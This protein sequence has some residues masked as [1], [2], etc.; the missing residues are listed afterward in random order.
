MA[1]PKQQQPEK[2][3][4]TL[5]NYFSAGSAKTSTAPANDDSSLVDLVSDDSSDEDNNKS[6]RGKRQLTTTKKKA[7]SFDNPP[8]KRFKTAGSVPIKNQSTS[9]SIEPSLQWV[10]LYKPSNSSEVA[11]HAKRRQEVEEA[12]TL[13]RRRAPNAPRLLMLSGPAGCSK[14]AIVNTLYKELGFTRLAEYETPSESTEDLGLMHAFEDFL[15]GIRYRGATD[16]LLVLVED[17]PNISHYE[18]KQAFVKALMQWVNYPQPNLPPLVLIMTEVE[19]ALEN[20]NYFS[21]DSIVVERIFPKPLL[22]HPQVK[23]IKFLPINMTL[24]SK[25]LK[26]VVQKESAK[27]AKLPKKEIDWA[28]RGLAELGDIRSAISGLEF[29]ARWRSRSNKLSPLG[30][31]SQLGLFHAIGRVVHGSHKDKKGQPVQSDEAVVESVLADWDLNNSDSSFNLSIAENYPSAHSSRT[32]IEG[33]DA[34]ADV[35]SLADT[36]IP[37]NLSQLSTDIAARGVRTALRNATETATIPKIHRPLVYSRY[38]KAMRE[39]RNVINDVQNYELQS[40]SLTGTKMS[41]QDVVLYHG[42]YEMLVKKK[43]RLG[44]GIWSSSDPNLQP[45]GEWDIESDDDDDNYIPQLTNLT[46]SAGPELSDEIE[47][48]DSS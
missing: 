14:T 18:T 9:P 24:I 19:I 11:L 30:R 5:L 1:R 21:S 16:G 48:S 31:E 17:L 22:M 6:N 35:L 33:L 8:A 40:C 41:P 12:L 42:F 4:G 3:K 44:G 47:D 23:R 29:W 45:E 32:S 20:K 7:V 28:V 38:W 10:D 27:F 36:L 46:V 2:R 13:M 37:N 25:T 26:S 39:R 34:C 43:K 15:D